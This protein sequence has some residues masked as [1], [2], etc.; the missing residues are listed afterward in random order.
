MDRGS[1]HGRID[2]SEFAGKFNSRTEIFETTPDAGGLAVER[3]ISRH[4][5]VGGNR[6]L[7]KG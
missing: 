5:L 4:G 1:G 2:S 7:V 6:R 3:R